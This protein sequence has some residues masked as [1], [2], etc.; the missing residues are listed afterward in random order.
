MMSS[1]STFGAN[2][3]PYMID[4]YELTGRAPS[5]EA[6]YEAEANGTPLEILPVDNPGVHTGDLPLDLSIVNFPGGD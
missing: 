1:P 4:D 3:I 6:F 5:T 2:G